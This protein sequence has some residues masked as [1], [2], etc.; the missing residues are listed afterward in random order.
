VTVNFIWTITNTNQAPVVDN[1]GNQ[2]TNEGAGVSLDINA[3]DPDGDT[4]L[5]SAANLP[6][7]LSI[8]ATTGQITGSPAFTAAGLYDVTILVSDNG[9]PSLSHTASF[10]WT[11]LNVNGPPTVGDPGSQTTAEGTNVSL[12]IVA[13][14]PD[15]N[16]MTYSAVGLPP[17]LGISTTTGLI[18]GAPLY[19]AAG[20]Y[21]VTVT[22]TDSGLL[23][24]Q[25]TFAW[26][27]INTNRPPVLTNPGQKTVAEGQ[28]V[29]I[30]M[31]ASDPEGDLLTYTVDGLPSS[32][33]IGQTTGLISG[34]TSYTDAGSYQ[35]T[36]TVS[37]GFFL[38]NP[39]ETFTL[40]ITNTNR[41]PL[42]TPPANQTSTEGDTISLPIV[43]TD[44]DGNPINDFEAGGLPPGL[45]IS[46]TTGLISGT[47]P[48][49][50]QGGYTVTVT[51]SDGP[52]FTSVVFTW[53]VNNLNRAPSVDSPVNVILPADDEGETVAYTVVAS[54]LDGDNL[55][56]IVGGLPQ[57]L[58]YDPDTGRMTGTISYLA[59]GAPPSSP[60]PFTSPY[61][62]DYLVTITASDGV[63]SDQES[64]TLRIN[65]TN[66]QPTVQAISSPQ[67]TAEGLTVSI[68][69]IATQPFDGDPLF[70]SLSSVSPVFPCLTINSATGTIS[71]ST[72]S[73]CTGTV[74]FTGDGDAGSYSVTVK[75]S[76]GTLSGQHT[77]TLSVFETNRAPV[78]TQPANQTTAEGTVVS[79]FPILAS[80]P[81]GAGGLTYG[82]TGLPSGLTIN[83]TTGV[84]SGTPAFDAAGAHTVTVVVSDAG[85][86][87]DT[88]EFTWTIQNTNRAPILMNPQN[89]ENVEG[90]AVS[91]QVAASDPDGDTLTYAAT[92]LP[93]DLVVDS[94]TGLISGD[95]LF[96]IAANYPVVISVTDNGTPLPLP[97][98]TSIT[99]NIT[100][101]NRPPTVTNPGDKT[102]T[103]GGITSFTIVASDPDAGGGSPTFSA[104][105]LPPGLSINSGNGQISGTIPTD[106]V[107]A[108]NGYSQIYNVTVTA[109]DSAS[110][111]GSTSF[112]YTVTN[113]NLAPVITNPGTQVSKGKD[114]SVIPATDG[115]IVSLQIVATDPDGDPLVNYTLTSCITG[116][117]VN[118]STGLISGTI[119]ALGTS[120]G[121]STLCEISVSDLGSNAGASSTLTQT[122]TFVWTLKT[123]NTAPTIV[124]APAAQ[125]NPEGTTVSLAVNGSDVENG[126]NSGLS[127]SATSLPAGLSINPT[128][129]LITGTI[130]STAAGVYNV[131]VRVSDAEFTTVANF[132]WEVTFVDNQPVVTDPPDQASVEGVAITDLQVVATDENPSSLIYTA[133]GLPGG[134]SIDLNTG[135][136][137]GTPSYTAAEDVIGGSYS[138][139]I[140]VSDG[141]S[142]SAPVVFVWKVSHSNNP[143]TITSPGTQTSTEADNISLDVNANDVDP[144]DVLVYMARNLPPGLSINGSSGLITGTIAFTAAAGSPYS[145]ELSVSDGAS[146]STQIFTWNVANKNQAP[147]LSAVASQL[148]P[149]NS[150]V[151]LQIVAADLDGDSL[152]YA[153]TNLPPA[154][155]IDSVTG[156][157]S[158]TV[159]FS[160]SSSYTVTIEVRDDIPLGSLTT[161]QSVT[162]TITN[163]NQLPVITAPGS[164]TTQE[165]TAANLQIQVSD[166][167][168]P[169]QD[170]D[171]QVTGLP[172]GLGIDLA[173][174]LITG[175]PLPTAATS[176]ASGVYTV[177]VFAYDTVGV[178]SLSFQWT[179]TNLNLSPVVQDPGDRTDTEEV[180]VSLQVVASDPDGGVLT[181]SAAGL[182]PGMEINTTTGEIF[183][184]LGFD[185][186]SNSVIYAVMVTATDAPEGAATSQSFDWTVANKNRAPDVTPPSDQTSAEG[187]VISLPVVATDP[188]NTAWSYSAVNLPGGLN[189]NASSG[190]ISGTLLFTSSGVYTVSVTVSDGFL[191]DVATFS[192]TVNNGN[193]A[194]I[195]TL[196]LPG[197]QTH[198]EGATISL[199]IP[200]TDPDNDGIIYSATNLPPGLSIDDAGTIFG[201]IDSAANASY[202]VT[203]TATDIPVSPFMP[204]STGTSFTWNITNTNQLPIITNPGNQATA[205][206]A[207][208]ILNILATEPDGQTMT[209]AAEN[210]PSGL[211]INLNNGQ[212]TGAPIFTAALS[213]P[214]TVTLTVTD[215]EGGISQTIFT[216]TITN[217]NQAPLFVNPLADQTDSEG[218]SISLQI[219]ANDPDGDT[220]TFSF[221]GA[222]PG[223]SIIASGAQAGLITGLLP[224]DAAA[225]YF[226]DVTITDGN[227]GTTHGTFTWT[228]NNTN[229]APVVTDPGDRVNPEGA[230][231]SLLITASDPDGLLPPHGA[232]LLYTATSLPPGLSIDSSTGVI[233]GLLPFNAAG[234]YSV[235]V[236]ASDGSLFGEAT[237]VWTITAGNAAPDLV[238]PGDQTTAEGVT[239]T[240][241]PIAPQ[242]MSLKLSASDPDGDTLTYISD[243]LPPD[244]S[245]NATTGEISGT[246]SYEAAIAGTPS[247]YTVIVSVVDGAG[248]SD[249]ETFTWTVNNTNRLPEIS[250]PAHLST[251][252]HAEDQVVSLSVL[253]FDLDGQSLTYSA[254]GLPPGLTIGATSGL[255]SGTTPFD[256]A[257][258]YTPKITVL[259]G[260]GNGV[261]DFFWTITVTNRA[262]VL[263]N[264]GNQTHAEGNASVSVQIPASD[265][266][267]LVPALSYT[268]AGLP[269]GLS[270][271]AATGIITGSLPFNAAGT[272]TVTLC[273]SDTALQSCLPI[274]WEITNTNRAPTVTNPG[275]KNFD[276][277]TVVSLLIVASD[278][279][280]NVLTYSQTGLPPSLTI[281]PATGLISGTLLFTEE[282]S[283]SVQV[284]VT[285]GTTPIT[286]SFALT[287]TNTNQRPTVTP[288]GNQTDSEGEVVNLPIVAA[289]ADNPPGTGLTYSAIGLPNG[290]SINSTTGVTSGTLTAT[291]VGVYAVSVTAAD[292]GGLSSSISFTWTVGHTNRA[293]VLSNPGDQSTLEDTSIALQITASDPDGDALGYSAPISTGIGLPPGLGINPVTGLISGILPFTAAGV[294]TVKI[295]ITDGVLTDTD[296]F[297]WT[298]TNKNRAPVLVNPG[299]PTLTE[300]V[301]ASI[302][303][304]ASD[305][306]T[307][308]EGDTL[309]YS[310]T[311]LSA[312]GFSISS[313]T[314]LIIGT[315]SFT[316][317][318]TYPVTIAVT[319]NPGG[320]PGGLTT[321]IPVNFIV[322]NSNR[323]PTISDPGAQT[324]A[325]NGFVELQLVANDLDGDQVTF[326][327][328]G[329]PPGLLITPAGLIT[330]TP[331]FT[332]TG[333]YTVTVVA[334][335]TALAGGSCFG[336]LEIPWTIQNTN[337]API[338]SNP[339]PQV[340]AEGTLFTLPLTAT[341]PDGD[342]VTYS[343]TSGALPGGLTL[344]ASTGV[345]G[346]TLSFESTG[347]HSIGVTASD[348]QTQ[349]PSS[350]QQTFSLTIV[351]TNRAP[352]FRAISSQVDAQGETIA[353]V[354]VVADDPDGNTLT[355]TANGLS[356]LGL[357]MNASGEIIGTIP[358]TALGTYSVQVVAFDGTLS[359]T[360]TISWEIVNTNRK[361]DLNPPGG[362]SNFEGDVVSLR[363]VAA[364][365]DGD[366]LT[367]AATGLPDSLSIN[368]VTGEITGTLLFD[369][370]GG[371]NVTITVTDDG[372][373]V[374]FDS[375]SFVWTVTNFNRAPV[376]PTLSARQNAE[377]EDLS[378]APV[379]IGATDPDGDALAYNA[380]NPATGQSLL[381]PGL[382]IA[383]TTGVITGTIAFNAAQTNGGVYSV[384]IFVSDGTLSDQETF[385][386]TISNSNQTPVVTQPVTQNTLEG[387]PVSLKVTASDPDA[388][389]L[390]FSATGLPPDL[391]IHAVTGIIT[392]IVSYEA[393]G[394][395]TQNYSVT[396]T[397]SDGLLSDDAP[398]TW[399][400]QNANRLPTCFNF[401]TPT[402]TEGVSFAQFFLADDADP[403]DVLTYQA[404]G[405]P[406]GLTMDTTTGEVSGT[407]PFT[408]SSNATSSYPVTLQA[409]DGAGGVCSQVITFSVKDVNQR[410]VVTA[411]GDLTHAENEP[412]AIN[413]L[414]SDP[415]GNALTFSAEGLPEGLKIGNVGG[416]ITGT[417]P[418]TAAGVYLVTINASDGLLVGSITFTWTITNTN[419]SPNLVSPGN[420]TFLEG[421]TVSLQ[422]VGSDPDASDLALTFNDL[423]VNGNHTLPP[424]L[425]LNPD[426][427]KITGLL[428]FDQTRNGR[429][430][431]VTVRI[432]DPHG[433]CSERAFTLNILDVNQAPVVDSC[434]ARSVPEGADVS[435]Q[436]VAA[437]PD[438]DAVVYSAS[439][440]PPGLS[441][442]QQSGII[443]GTLGF[444]S[445]TYTVTVVAND[446]GLNG[447]TTCSIVVTN[448]NRCPTLGVQE[449][450]TKAE[451]DSVSL[452]IFASD[453][454]GGGLTFTATGL[455]AGLSMDSTGIIS[456]VISLSAESSYSTTVTVSDGVCTD[457]VTFNW[458]ITGTNQPPVISNPGAQNMAEGITLVPPIKVTATDPDNDPVTFSAVGLPPG[459]EINT[460]TGEITGTITFQTGQDAKQY[461]V[462]ITADDGTTTAPTSFTF[463]VLNV[464]RPPVLCTLSDQV[465]AQG[466]L[467]SL[468]LSGCASDLDG[469]LLGLSVSGL[470]L[471]LTFD[472]PTGSISGTVAFTAPLGAS[473][474]TVTVTD[475]S[476]SVSKTF[477]WT[478]SG[479]NRAPDINPAPTGQT[480]T[481][482]TPFSDQ[483]NGSDPDG[484]KALTYTITWSPLPAP[485][486]FTISTTGTGAGLLTGTFGF[487]EATP[488]FNKTYNV[489]VTVTDSGGLISASKTFAITITNTNRPPEFTSGCDLVR[490]RGDVF[491]NVMVTATDLDGEALNFSGVSGLSTLGIAIG[492]NGELKGTVSSTAPLGVN[493]FTI[494]V[495]DGTTSVGKSCLMTVKGVNT[496]PSL[497]GTISLS[498]VNEGEAVSFQVLGTDPDAG[499]VL[500]YTDLDPVTSDPAIQESHTLPLGLAISKTGLITGVVPYAVVS[501]TEVTRDYTVKI[502]VCDSSNACDDTP[503]FGLRVKHVNQKPTCSDPGD[504]TGTKNVA[505]TP[506]FLGCADP[507][508]D[509]LTYSAPGLPGGLS[510]N[511]GTGE[512]S[513]TP[514]STSVGEF[515][516]TGQV[517]D[518]LLL[519]DPVTFTYKI[520]DVPQPNTNPTVLP[521]ADKSNVKGQQITDFKI[522]ASDLESHV[523]TYTA[524][525]LPPG[526]TLDPATGIISGTPTTL[527][528]FTVVLTAIEVAPTSLS[529]NSVTFKWTIAD[530]NQCPTITTP[531]AQESVE[532]VA[533][534]PFSLGVN[535]PEGGAVFCTLESG[536]LPTGLSLD[537]NTCKISGT[538]S[539]PGDYTFKVK[540]QDSA[541]CTATSNT[542]SWKVVP[543]PTPPTAGIIF[544]PTSVAK[545]APSTM[546]IT[547]TNA[548]TIS[549]TG[550]AFTT[551]ANISGNIPT[552][553]LKIT[554]AG[555]TTCGGTLTAAVGSTNVTLSGGTIPAAVGT[556]AGSCVVTVGVAASLADTYFV[557]GGPV[558]S[559]QAAPSLVA[560][561]SLTVTL[562][563]TNV[564]LTVTAPTNGKVTG[565]GIDCGSDC[566]DLV[567]QNSSVMLTAVANAGFVFG[568]W[569][570]DCT[571]TTTPCTVAMGT[572]N[573]TVS[574]TFTAAPAD[575]VNLT[576][577]PVPG[578]GKVTGTGIDCGGTCTKSVAPSTLITLTA[579]PDTGYVFASWLGA[580]AGTTTEICTVDMGTA[581]K[582][583]SA[584][585]TAAPADNV[586]LTVD[587]VPGNGKVMGT[588]IDCGSD[589]TESVAQ[590]SS[591]TLTAVANAGFVFGS[592]LGACA[593]T[594]TETCTVAMGTANK[595]VSATFTAAPP[596]QVTLTVVKVGGNNGTVTGSPSGINCGNACT[597]LVTTGGSVT[598]T[599]DPNTGFVVS[600]SESHCSS[601]NLTCAVSMTQDKT[602]TVTFA[603]PEVKITISPSTVTLTTGGKQTFTATVT[604]TNDLEVTWIQQSDL[605]GNLIGTLDSNGNYTAPTI[606]GTYEV[607]VTHTTSN[608]TATATVI[609]TSEPVVSLSVIPSVVTLPPG[610]TQAF[611]V[612]VSGSSNQGVS[613]EATGGT[614]SGNV[615]TAPTVPGMYQITIASLADS[616]K[617]VTITVTV[618]APPNISILILPASATVKTGGSQGFSA[619]VTDSGNTG[620]TWSV[621]ESGGGT[622]TSSGVYT[623][624]TVVGTY[625]V[626]AVSAADTTKSATASVTVT[627]DPVV[628]VV[629]SPS[630]AEVAL[631]GSV[632]FTATVSDSTSE[633]WSVVGGNENGMVSAA[634]LYTAPGVPGTYYVTASA[635]SASATA[636][637][638]VASTPPVINTPSLPRSV[639]VGDTVNIPIDADAAGDG[640]LT[641]DADNLP[642]GLTIDPETGVI[643]GTVS[644]GA[645][646]TY[647]VTIEVCDGANCV[648]ITLV[649]T[650]N[651]AGSTINLP[652]VLV[653]PGNRINGIN[654]AIS[655][656][657]VASDPES[658]PLTYSA[659]GLPANLTM[660]S[661]TGLISGTLSATANTGSPYTVTLTVE[662][663]GASGL[664]ATESFVWKVLSTPP[665]NLAPIVQNPGNK[666][667]GA[668]DVITPLQI[669]AS[670]PNGDPITFNISGLPTGLNMNST[671]QISGTL[672]DN[673][674]LDSPY[675]VKV[676]VLDGALSATQSFTWDVAAKGTVVPNASPS[677]SNPGTQSGVEGIAILPFSLVATDPNGDTLTFSA[678]GLP[679][680]L[681]LNPVSGG[682][683]GTPTADGTYN[684]EVTVSD[685]PIEVAQYFTWKIEPAGTPRT[686]HPPVLTQPGDKI[687]VVGET[688]APLQLL[689]SDP[690]GDTLSF[691]ASALPAGL[692]ISPAG[693]I[694]GTPQGAGRFTVTAT[695][696]D[697]PLSATQSWIW[698]IDP[699]LPP[700]QTPLNHPP[701]V[702]SPGDKAGVE[703]QAITPIQVMASDPDGDTLTFSAT[704]L[705]LGVSIDTGSGFITG[706]PTDN[707]KYTVRV[708]VSD[709]E[710]SASAYFVLNITAASVGNGAPDVQNPGSKVGVVGTTI[711]PL[712]IVASDPD[713][714]DLTFAVSGLPAGIKMNAT[715]QIS[716]TPTA[717]VAV[718]VTVTVSDG[719]LSSPVTFTWTVTTVPQ[720]NNPPV[721]TPADPSEVPTDSST[722]T[723][724]TPFQPVVPPTDPEGDPLTCSA[725]G[726]PPGLSMDPVTCFI[727]GTP[728][729]P[730]TYDD[731]VIIVSDGTTETRVTL[732]P[733]VVDFSGNDPPTVSSPP[734]STTRSQDEPISIQI[735]ATDPEGQALTYT[736]T[737]LPPGLSINPSTGL[738]SG[739]PTAQGSYTVRVTVSDGSVSSV[740]SFT[741]TISFGGKVASCSA[742]TPSLLV[743]RPANLRRVPISILGVADPIITKIVQ[744]EPTNT[745]NTLHTAVDG[746]GIGKSR[747]WVR[748]ERRA[749][750]NGRIYQIFFNAKDSAGAA[751]MGSVKVGVP[752]SLSRPAADDGIRYDATVPGS[753]RR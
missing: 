426:T 694:S 317:V 626:K 321:S 360:E 559:T 475:G 710:L 68:P 517:G 702:T 540:V 362:K 165:G 440:L 740:V 101:T 601:A 641:Y 211:T 201:V 606:P 570:G 384:T 462:T 494:E 594:T 399:T 280:G 18:T 27:I 675:V 425:E 30:Q 500:T 581:N 664:S 158:G 166:A 419:Q 470:P 119:T 221:A 241:S 145:V 213:S 387:L 464:N 254:T 525:N 548:N 631:G 591:V 442:D 132:T 655:L 745:L 717:A 388:N 608:E 47:L 478:I 21:S 393:G 103:E 693:Q 467:V 104:A 723:P 588:G 708:T 536:T 267:G 577:D 325:E 444:F 521:I 729:T 392:G 737:G 630:D 219:L 730:G 193:A 401:G 210:I 134:I 418:F 64:F 565:T 450:Q 195:F 670:D 615:Y 40:V 285:D 635:G 233:S 507:D 619:V 679:S 250:D 571:G 123:S 82:A 648:T 169:A 307:L 334:S 514:Q 140:S 361:P 77:F 365:P 333:S 51:A 719:T 396:V 557:S 364:D 340:G 513:G 76:D 481:E 59:A 573:K 400:I 516:V 65:N 167:D 152:I 380:L 111:I 486:G 632:A 260:E 146:T 120:L 550:V 415:D 50:A 163:E 187:A 85:G 575:N 53:T 638:T 715:G 46:P 97:S 543:P 116:V 70:H 197:N 297:I 461:S 351:P 58:V 704:G 629:V 482:G 522:P 382:S 248:L 433:A 420:Q 532:D 323:C 711:V 609:V 249:S 115:A 14:D 117:S 734:A 733:F 238:H 518:G 346:G 534:T 118:N 720:P 274:T 459:L 98:S 556:V 109:T 390:T 328:S 52:L 553:N 164:Q 640:T 170:I 406:P 593:G 649:I 538:P 235:T 727:T 239:L 643:S 551:T 412:I 391:T 564:T 38:P 685:G 429:N 300:G 171:Y 338:L 667:N 192:W 437:D 282:N 549:L 80:D 182:P 692:G 194:P 389:P 688:I 428:P 198:A 41:Q 314:G 125:N 644:S 395:G 161:S 716:G 234:N 563:T 666:S 674:D 304:V 489:T 49:N 653:N 569:S 673:A 739:T 124:P 726:L 671:G 446:G 311:G 611:T 699:A 127:Y 74:P 377:G 435:I 72:V 604:G 269:P 654:E 337:Q 133:S 493:S 263:T 660:D 245:L 477:T 463:N 302:Q 175:S 526:L 596:A 12:Q 348:N 79:S 122:T 646:G 520:F 695:V 497:P 568:S 488:T 539:T 69:V 385:L 172:P 316:A 682:V 701:T 312:L 634:G 251:Q 226:V 434:A 663:P 71:I 456:G 318:G 32:L 303:L 286:I 449:D 424:N 247:V 23:S 492:N 149:E 751:C 110:L 397:A 142:I 454:D 279:D 83:G 31:V 697:G 66:Q 503:V 310:A 299:N 16:S 244:L 54:D 257:A 48:T 731:I 200:A 168:V 639:K 676:T 529:S 580:C 261:R 597:E 572:A 26:T 17:G 359:D 457:T 141:N 327:A 224:H 555:T 181:Y 544:S 222:P 2:T 345:I 270:V 185:P 291:S 330:G 383:P 616:T 5:Y 184:T 44:P 106:T 451:G 293:P 602:V 519:S 266:D 153:A 8:N 25:R 329:L 376:I 151:S 542:L 422:L 179:V 113:K 439:G 42:V 292:S 11:V 583:A 93:P 95:V 6:Q 33:N 366:N 289:D 159:L 381:P 357:S 108:A 613:F 554:T 315:P 203:V 231:I 417:P 561:G 696:S 473:V 732:P 474:V 490:S 416:K 476:P 468:S 744:D 610:G 370:A 242:V 278:L 208:V 379:S 296:T 319:D 742:A 107:S 320:N 408:A 605:F 445:A 738:I 452:Q 546:T 690:D 143:P 290:L 36:V 356:I 566:T 253:A 645:G 180:Y 721:V 590:N 19:T 332:A 455:P 712:Q 223:L 753:L 576:V 298:I 743:I 34:I 326:S 651:P 191:T 578:N 471:G 78:L 371:Y 29:S 57:G 552:S 465:S 87:V 276:E 614:F 441:I 230:A 431:A 56:F 287:V 183:G 215:Q 510:V 138:V 35:V 37:D 707:E 81:D 689:A 349:N 147:I 322:A 436:I 126:G 448:K 509:T 495:S 73:P 256:T 741:L 252:V 686:N 728:T 324:S 209:Y 622:I 237:F 358:F 678:S 595:T 275:S 637:I 88:A 545:D 747:A 144:A 265:P 102:S 681:S 105:G 339:G 135:V 114:T 623:A 402:L 225:T 661:T 206:G 736:A 344:N 394:V 562:A 508:G 155:T 443:S 714:N 378:T 204:L 533:I 636:K 374:L 129:G 220:V 480:G 228:V 45:G 752:A 305:P 413:I 659:T 531:S 139:T 684:V 403:T 227:G 599:A 466:A 336:T 262:P 491:S 112:L 309:T 484:D 199:S 633:T 188:E 579:V 1:P 600:W 229:Q 60:V 617:K 273:A 584:T 703:N 162:W 515:T 423:D 294:Y 130:S 331:P 353:K 92:G 535:D 746:G 407:P 430:H 589:C 350:A 271:N 264:P 677:L 259:D 9:V 4:L 691:T 432:C 438:G 354:T 10:N 587:P 202:S 306:D 15:G 687:A 665:V 43:A 750:G 586:N 86:L 398:F 458:T 258:T 89:Q 288:P 342:S 375:E 502:T 131:A 94:I 284:T 505:I 748:A 295:E 410:P 404:T 749:R 411:P 355:Y 709:S 722:D 469:D 598:L 528:D 13:S 541:L 582:T 205:E 504:K 3:T 487:D 173:T 621:M 650:V 207:D 363:M 217:T 174:G 178:S 22:V 713:N 91:F 367:Y 627:T 67:N 157:I 567:A 642:P 281:N 246:L 189:I 154:L 511:P 499:D 255:I 214:Y 414:A 603:L 277:G 607:R 368:A 662:E 313:S 647:N 625:T 121:D 592:W 506:F 485:A 652:P 700:G 560:S 160:A 530:T 20:N 186:S 628:S 683:T 527:G 176:A 656:P 137:S 706:T 718:T 62:K 212:I 347:V 372:S 90:E 421:A 272:Y 369:E 657:V 725:T 240:G 373:P 136:I 483:I 558:T 705:P 479:T 735:S 216:W 218:D 55:T 668:G 658:Q 156:L 63:L 236:R 190:L 177:T 547:L 268:A 472:S 39:S 427:G 196:P 150:L 386:W 352:I 28:T 496:P 148:T 100:T 301:V 501:K 128:T 243:G 24:T 99:W 7:G 537:T 61:F 447:V 308:D 75:A 585:F 84:I 698:T 405:L 524:T 574:A 460:T 409:L 283:Y 624:P 672:A 343:L 620:V 341:D 96:E 612:T 724:I 523:L 335:D 618:E 680:G 669:G 232:P 453:L 498:Q 512:I